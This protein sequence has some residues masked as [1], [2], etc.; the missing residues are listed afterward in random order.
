MVH[1]NTKYWSMTWETNVKQKKLPNEEALLSFFDRI[2]DECVFQYE[3]GAKKKKEHVQGTFTLSGRRQSKTS[4]LKLFELTFKNVGGLTI[5]QV[6]D[7]VAIKSY[8]TKDEGR[9]K[10]PFYGGKKEM[11]D[12]QMASCK[13][14]EWQKQL[15]KIIT[16]PEQEALKDRKVIWV[17]DSYGS[18]GKSW[19]AKWLR[20]GQKQLLV[21]GLPVSSVDRLSS[22]VNIINK[23]L[24]VDA[25]TIDL[26]RTQGVDQSYEDLF[27]QIEQIK[28][29][30]ILDVMYG[31][32]NEAIFKPPL[33]MIFTNREHKEF[34][35]Y[36]SQDRWKVF[37]ISPD[38][39]LAESYS[40][41]ENIR[42]KDLIKKE[43]P[44]AI[45]SGL[46]GD[47]QEGKD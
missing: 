3:K 37:V 11:Y 20:I 38:G 6:Y 13:L 30:Y 28:N 32:Y 24:K 40:P 12:K 4:V 34:K 33:V 16:G 23:T 18:T 14:R 15:F 8:V 1:T 25:Y 36:L 5:S 46:A 2:A 9:T 17:Q 10:G 47:A 7:K 35:H 22:A 43:L 26:T 45:T 42:V 19:F 29:G 31:K 27:A 41:Y 21:R 44:E 39:D